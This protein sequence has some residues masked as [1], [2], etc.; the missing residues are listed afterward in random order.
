M[1]IYMRCSEDDNDECIS[2]GT[3]LGTS[4]D[5]VAILPGE[6]RQLVLRRMFDEASR[7]GKPATDR[8]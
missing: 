4:V 1:H 2:K 7:L 3:R 5:L 8:P 6:V